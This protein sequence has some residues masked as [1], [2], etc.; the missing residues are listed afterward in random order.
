[1]EFLEING[2]Y[3]EGGGQIIRSALT[4]SCITNRPIWIKDIRK[5]RKKPGLMKQHLT[6]IK[7][8][9]ELTDCQVDGD[10]FGSTELKFI[11]GIIKNSK[12]SIDVGSAGSIS[13]ILQTIIPLACV[14]EEKLEVEIIGGTDVLWSPTLD[15]TNYIVKEAYNR[16]GINFSVS[17]NKRGYYPKGGGR[18]S[19]DIFPS[20]INS[21]ELTGEE[22]SNLEIICSYA[23]ISKEKI[24]S[25]VK[26]I[27]QIFLEN[28]FN[29]NYKIN[30]FDSIDSGASIL[31]YGIGKK[32]IFGFDSLLNFDENFELDS[33][34][35]FNFNCGVDDYLADM[36][37]VLSCIAN[38]KTR[39]VVKNITKH[40]ETNLFVCSKI[41]GSKYGIGKI[42]NNYEIIIE[43]ISYSSV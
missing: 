27:N 2:G 7:I 42:N 35:I 15:Y 25:N 38:G 20:K 9:K 39:F 10:T 1:M 3:G 33:E 17:V 36:L 30:E 18:V 14:I 32:S 6:V 4:I 13:L 26:K 28:N 8:L 19:I 11:P 23:K 43:G 41:S 34:M 29:V 22:I 24:I 5:N 21:I 37:V 31:I 12:V 40:L 16:M